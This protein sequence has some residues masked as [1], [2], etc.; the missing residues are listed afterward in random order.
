MWLTFTCILRNRYMHLTRPLHA[1]DAT[2]T[3]IWRDRPSL[4]FDAHM[5]SFRENDDEYSDD[6][7]I[8]WKVRRA[9]AK[10]LAAIL[11]SRP[12][13]LVEF[14]KIV[15]PALISRFKGTHL[16]VMHATFWTFVLLLYPFIFVPH[17]IF[18]LPSTLPT[19]IFPSCRTGRECKSGH[20]HRLSRPPQVH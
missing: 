1:F 11:G 20:F 17:H 13:M 9:S 12:E 15:S 6:D 8:S 2:F 16:C 7:D 14:Y 4:A 3:C 18:H 19:D 5:T 10:C